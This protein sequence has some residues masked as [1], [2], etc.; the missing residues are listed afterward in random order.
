MKKIL[1]WVFIILISLFCF[2]FFYLKDARENKLKKEGNE[3]VQRIENFRTKNKRLP[4]SLQEL[5]SKEEESGAD[6]IFYDKRD[7]SNYTVSFAM[8]IDY[9]KFYYSDTK[10][11][12][13]GYRAMK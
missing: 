3:L 10:R 1:A 6:A 5:G 7:S 2:W 4:N 9:N 12:E 11:W 13:D 8:S